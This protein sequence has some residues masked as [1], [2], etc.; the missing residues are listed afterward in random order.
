MWNL[1][2]DSMREEACQ[3]A[4]E[5]AAA[6]AADGT[7][8]GLADA[9]APVLICR[10]AA[11]QPDAKVMIMCNELMEVLQDCSAAVQGA[12]LT[13]VCGHCAITPGCVG[14]RKLFRSHQAGVSHCKSLLMYCR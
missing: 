11:A 14:W 7:G 5:A 10:Q 9:G 3:T 6:E 13:E 1:T 4:N 12:T 2:V 8:G